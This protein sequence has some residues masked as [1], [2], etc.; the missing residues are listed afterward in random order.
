MTKKRVT[1]PLTSNPG[2]GRPKEH[3]SYL[4]REEMGALRLLNGNN[5][6]RGPRGL[7][8]FPPADA[9]GSSSK[10]SSGTGARG[11]TGP[12]GQA[13]S[14]PAGNKGGSPGSVSRTSTASKS[15]T[16][17]S[18]GSSSVS[19]ISG[20]TAGSNAARSA[21]S[22]STGGGGG[23]ARDSGQAANRPASGSGV[24]RISGG[25]PSGNQ[26][27][28]RFLSYANKEN[29][30]YANRGKNPGMSF[31]P[32]VMRGIGSYLVGGGPGALPRLIS[33]GYETYYAD[34][35]GN[36]APVGNVLSNYFKDNPM[37]M[38]GI[39][40]LSGAGPV[41]Y[42]RAAQSI[43]FRPIPPKDDGTK[44]YGFMDPRF[45]FDQMGMVTR[46]DPN[47]VVDP[48][49]DKSKDYKLGGF[50]TPI[51]ANT[52]LGYGSPMERG[53]YQTLAHELQ[54]V[55]QF[56][57]LLSP[58]DSILGDED[59]LDRSAE[60]K[61]RQ[62]YDPSP[63]G[64]SNYQGIEYTNREL[65]FLDAREKLNKDPGYKSINERATGQWL[66]GVPGYQGSV[67]AGLS[68]L[69]ANQMAEES[70][71]LNSLGLNTEA[72]RYTLQT[73]RLQGANNPLYGQSTM[74]EYVGIDYDIRRAIEDSEQ[75]AKREREQKVK[76]AINSRFG[77]ARIR[78]SMP[79]ITRGSGRGSLR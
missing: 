41:D 32:M 44:V 15:T 73:A 17:K 40:T 19:R 53:H 50:S 77:S 14:S 21:L 24:S 9:K 37:A 54:H 63:L 65:D 42:Y 79:T 59:V 23:G 78:P 74:P 71:R 72:D 26:E 45:S 62:A 5:M 7:P 22:G 34:K 36:V 20:G 68:A 27:R 6:E 76:N 67:A 29:A 28:A 66:S 57:H 48:T 58:N 39:K 52:K 12:Q 56:S 35:K 47:V 75:Q 18:S 13:R 51:M 55:G 49:A 1:A 25:T 46:W 60:L 30:Y 31:T 64:L 38:T 43:Q 16:S 10:A 33:P 61:A 70:R 2:K 4:N 11:P 69:A 3:L 8:S